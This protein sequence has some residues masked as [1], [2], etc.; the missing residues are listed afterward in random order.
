MVDFHLAPDRK[1]KED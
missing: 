1:A